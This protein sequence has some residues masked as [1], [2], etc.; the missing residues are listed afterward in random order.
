MKFGSRLLDDLAL[1]SATV[2]FLKSPGLP[3]FDSNKPLLGLRFG[4][5]YGVLSSGSRRFLVIGEEIWRDDLL[6]GIE[7][8]T[9]E[10]H[11]V[12]REGVEPPVYINASTPLFIEFLAEMQA[13]FEAVNRDTPVPVTM[14]EQQARMRLE[15]FRRG[16]IKPAPVTGR[17]DREEALLR[18]SENFR[19]LDPRS[20]QTAWWSRILEQARDGLI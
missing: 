13:C 18:I 1:P 19:R 4:D 16:E 15:A 3:V 14:T 2:D 17:F 8:A 5:E 7:V 6:I 9:G 12:F 10:V 20:I 11:A